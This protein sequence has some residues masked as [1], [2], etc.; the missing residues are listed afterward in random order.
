MREKVKLT[1]KAGLSEKEAE[2]SRRAHGSNILSRK[3]RD[4]F[5]KK[6]LKS[7]GDPMIKVLLVALAINLI[8]VIRSAEWYEPLGITAS[9]LI[10][11]LISTLSEWGSESAFE[12]LQ[13]DAA[14]IRCKARRDGGVREAAIDEIVVGDRIILQTGDKI[15]ADGVLVE[16][17]LQVDQSAL[18]GESKEARKTAAP[19][20]AITNRPQTTNH[21]RVGDGVLD[22]PQTT[23]IPREQN[24]GSSET[25]TYDVPTPT[26]PHNPADFLSPCG[27]FRGTVVCQGEGEMVVTGVGNGTFYGQMA[28][29]V[30]QDTRKSPLHIRL[31]ELA[32]TISALGY[33]C[34]GLVGLAYIFHKFWADFGGDIDLFLRHYS[35]FP[36]LISD[37]MNLI[38]MVVTVIVVAVPEGLPMMITVVLSAN[39]RK[40]Q[41]DN[42][43]VRKMTGIETAGSMNILFTDKTGTLTRGKFAVQTLLTGDGL[44][45]HNLLDPRLSKAY[46]EAVAVGCGA[47]TGA[48]LT[49]E[50][51]RRK[52][53]GGNATDR[54][55]LE[56][57]KG[58]EKIWANVVKTGNVPF[59]SAAK[60]SS[61]RINQDEILIKGSPDLL[62]P[63]CTKYLGEDGRERRAGG[64]GRL[65]SEMA[66]LASQSMRLIALCRSD[67]PI[68][69]HNPGR[70]LT[71]VALLG[72]RDG[73]RS[74]TP[75]AIRQMRGAGI[76][77]VMMTGDS[78]ETATAIA[79]ECGLILGSD[80]PGAPIGGAP[81]GGVPNPGDPEDGVIMT[82]AELAGYTDAQL[83]SLLP[84]LRVVARALPSDKS[85]LVRISQEAGLVVGMTGDGVNDAPALKAADVG[86][87]MG[88]G[89]EVAKEASDV[90]IM[91]DNIKSIGKAV[92]YGRTIFK[93]VR[94]FIIYQ[95]TSNLCAV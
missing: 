79:K 70:G 8:V 7:F 55:L 37:L 74:E 71:L 86:F 47:N 87:G 3:K 23:D 41:K 34:S 15:P 40:M 11:T 12:K 56:F 51:G 81:I 42:V 90:V 54:A 22:I 31:T 24:H 13:A 9:I 46:L 38:T 83:Q 69:L 18:N 50:K 20:G 27:L 10:A 89:S 76:Q 78:K 6:Y 68:D 80:D 75:A 65:K 84:R 48:S 92:L 44:I 25:Y 2:A 16:G 17:E 26:A 82:S 85:R 77:V 93:S 30:Q 43:L 66:A 58:E 36:A 4:P 14:R 88:S 53:I 19:V 64:F 60:F 72:V 33:T 73:I 91:D 29:E 94:K 95:L 39:I 21:P 59:S 57:V 32:K 49:R 28:Q 1:D 52:A 67:D 45:L 61:A 5:I 63:L 35:S 62:I